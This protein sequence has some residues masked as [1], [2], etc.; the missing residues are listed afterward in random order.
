MDNTS[1]PEMRYVKSQIKFLAQEAYRLELQMDG[2]YEAL[3]DSVKDLEGFLHCV[4]QRLDQY[5]KA[6]VISWRVTSLNQPSATSNSLLSGL[7]YPA[8]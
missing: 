3:S 7:K 6:M 1:T 2:S 5:E 4:D 8:Y